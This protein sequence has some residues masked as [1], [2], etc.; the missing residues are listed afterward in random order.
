MPITRIQDLS[1][2]KQEIL[3]AARGL[4]SKKGFQTASM[5]DL[6][7]TLDIK[8]ASLYSHYQS[9]DEIL[10][11]I[12]IRCAREFLDTVLPLSE[13]SL[14]VEKRLEQM[15]KAHI[16][17]IIRNQ[18]ASAIFF[19]E[20]IHLEEPRRSEYKA[21]IDR[22]ESAF[23]QLIEEGIGEGIFR[24]AN[25]RF[26]TS[27]MIAS[28]NWIHQWYR[29]EGKMSVEDI[30]NEAAH[31]ILAGLSVSPSNDTNVR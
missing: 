6:A 4:F 2:R 13:T 5:R 26:T 16:S 14:P 20:W 8:P 10:W 27:M 25:P 1:L 3:S 21:L 30:G 24:N 28:I 17:V 23:I 18:D 7:Q 12:A 29:P 15:V 9:K 22:Y 11:E 19:Q 31:F